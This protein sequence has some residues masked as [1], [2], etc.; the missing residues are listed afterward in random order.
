[1]YSIYK[2]TS[3]SGRSYIGLTK[4][5]ISERWR[6]HVKRAYSLLE[7][8]PFYNAIRCYLP[9][10]F[11]VEQIDTANSKAEAQKLEQKHI[12]ESPVGYLYNLSPGGEADGEAGARIFW[13]AM[14]ENPEAKAAYLEK[15]SKVKL[16]DDWSDYPAMSQRAQEWRAANPA[17]AYHA[18]RRALRIASRSGSQPPR[19]P[20]PRTLKD[21]LMWK[22]KRA[23]CT[24]ENAFALWARRTDAERSALAQKISDKA[25]ARWAEVTDPAERS[26]KTAAARAAIDRGKQGPAASAGIKR[27]WAELRQDPV[28]YAEYMA[29]RVATRK[30]KNQA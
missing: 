26:A 10:S 24:R 12:A 25:V 27:F 3:P 8:K 17:E 30:A 13:Q 11:L 2:I 7:N 18:S 5:K 20:A 9:E 19:E 16:E 4:S 29:R 22:H 15:L 21:R 28:R 1:M 6:Q 14:A 23:A